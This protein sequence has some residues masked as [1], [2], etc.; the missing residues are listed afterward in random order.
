M[1]RKQFSDY[2]LSDIDKEELNLVANSIGKGI[3][4]KL[5]M[6]PQD[7][8][9]NEGDGKSGGGGGGG[10]KGGSK[11]SKG[12]GEG[13]GK[14]GGNSDKEQEK[15]DNKNQ[16][17]KNDNNKQKGGDDSQSH[18]GVQ[19]KEDKIK[20][21]EEQIKN[22]EDLIKEAKENGLDT[23]GLES[24]LNDLKKAKEFL[25]NQQES[26]K[27]ESVD[28]GT[29]KKKYNPNISDGTGIDATALNNNMEEQVVSG[30][31]SGFKAILSQLINDNGTIVSAF[32]EYILNVVVKR[33]LAMQSMFD[34]LDKTPE[35]VYKPSP[36]VSQRDKAPAQAART[37][38]VRSG[39]SDSR[40]ITPV[41]RTTENMP[42]AVENVKSIFISI[43]DSGSM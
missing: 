20:S 10:S 43:D 34:S 16:G 7:G 25:E 24:L 33:G 32:I 14:G 2:L 41:V 22:V 35:S 15:K 11:G 18:G 40:V 9:E 23:S 36:G 6:P 8:G 26:D 12:K 37:E 5:N 17:G 38:R 42:F 1:I 3:L 31:R 27:K 28:K 21:L 30:S 4:S 29:K 19:N 39:S 13:K